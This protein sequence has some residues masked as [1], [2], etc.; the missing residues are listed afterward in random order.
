MLYYFHLKKVEGAP[1]EARTPNNQVRHTGFCPIDILGLIIK[2]R[3]TVRCFIFVFLL[4]SKEYTSL[5]LYFFEIRFIAV[6]NC[7]D[8]S[9][10]IT[11]F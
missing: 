1:G 3:M 4:Y 6:H 7:A 11:P 5:S 10:K 9:I 8:N 2:H